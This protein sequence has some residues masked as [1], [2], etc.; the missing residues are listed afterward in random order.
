MKLFFS[1]ILAGLLLNS[2]E[3]VPKCVN[4]VYFQN[5]TTKADMLSFQ[6]K[7]YPPV[8]KKY[9]GMILDVKQ[10]EFRDYCPVQDEAD[11]EDGI[12]TIHF[13]L[14][15]HDSTMFYGYILQGQCFGSFCYVIP[16]SF[17]EQAFKELQE[18]ERK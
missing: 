15:Y 7:L 9:K 18:Q 4:I 13:K 2:C 11:M 12:C 14:Q 8:L 10:V 5:Q 1:L 17:S 6:G 3:S 16:N